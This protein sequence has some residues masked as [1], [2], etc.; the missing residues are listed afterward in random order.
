MGMKRETPMHTIKV[1]TTKGPNFTT[2][3]THKVSRHRQF[4]LQRVNQWVDPIDVVWND[5]IFSTNYI[6]VGTRGELDILLDR[7]NRSSNSITHISATEV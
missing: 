1:E 4:V 2:T 5:G 3:K 6:T 7:L